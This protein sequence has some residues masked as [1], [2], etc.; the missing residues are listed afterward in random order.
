[1][2]KPSSREL[3]FAVDV[4]SFTKDGF[5]G[6]TSV[7]GKRVEI[8]FDDKEQGVFLTKEIAERIGARKGSRVEV[9]VDAEDR[10]QVTETL[11][12]GIRTAPRLSNAKVY[13]G[14]GRSG[15][16]VIRIRKP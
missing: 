12:E 5:L 10:L 15:G 4:S 3:V 11:V 16:A 9:I 2:S 8:E 1:V 13:Y 7:G 6:S 14:V